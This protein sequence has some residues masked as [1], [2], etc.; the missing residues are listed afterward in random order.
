MYAIRSYYDAVTPANL[1]RTLT[2]LQN[3]LQTQF[4]IAQP[5]ILVCGLNPHAGEGGH[6]GRE[7]IDVIEPR[8]TSY[9]V[10]YTKLLRSITANSLLSSTI[11]FRL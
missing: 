2:I 3:D 6:M 11:R 10:C 8:I 9:N 1:E 4:G 7:E 5:H